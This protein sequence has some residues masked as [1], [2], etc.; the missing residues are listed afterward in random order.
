MQKI[1]NW[2]VAPIL[3]VP[4]VLA[5]VEYFRSVLGFECGPGAI[6]GGVGD[7]GAVYALLQR[8]GA[9]VHLQIRRRPLDLEARH[10]HEGDVYLYVDDVD[11]L[12]AEYRSKN[13]KLYRELQNE[14]YGVRDFTIETPDGHRLA[15]GTRMP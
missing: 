13:V 14:Q 7:E 11:A 5:S 2:T 8:G 3:G 6:F 10:A 9:M 4:D 15:F 12:Y 1:T